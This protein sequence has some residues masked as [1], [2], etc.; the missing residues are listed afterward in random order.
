MVAWHEYP[1]PQA[2]GQGL[3]DAVAPLLSA[4]VARNSRAV[5]AV[6][7]GTTPGPFLAALAGH[8]LPW[9]RITLMPTDERFV[10][11]DDEQSNERM[12]RASMPVLASGPAGWVSFHGQ[13]ETLEAAAAALDARLGS[14]P[15]LDIVVSGM[16]AD[17]HIA[18][19][20]PG[21]PALGTSV[22]RHVVPARPPG[23]PPRLSLAPER[24]VE[25]GHVFLL[26]GGAAKRDALERATGK[27]PSEAPV[28]LL[29]GR[30]GPV[31]IYWAATA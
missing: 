27:D 4:A 24:L 23:L 14:L 6:P 2:A 15:P 9:D 29:L 10:A 8:D 1:T 30:P 3:A 13:G 31:D 16:G 7:G 22:S 18:S 17:A 20:F 25:A 19:L 21:D 26:V 5:L 28:S 11:P 12:I